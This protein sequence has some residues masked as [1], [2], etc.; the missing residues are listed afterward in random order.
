M[1]TKL[2]IATLVTLGLCGVPA[3]HGTNAEPG[4]AEDRTLAKTARARAKMSSAAQ[5]KPKGKDGSDDNSS[6]DLNIGNTTTTR[7]GTGPREIIVVVT[8]DVINANNKCK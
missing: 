6:C 2:W 5:S 3:A 1:T 8:G 4:D 7:P